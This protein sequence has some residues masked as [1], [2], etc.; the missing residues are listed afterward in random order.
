MLGT[1][2]ERPRMMTSFGP[3]LW[4]MRPGNHPLVMFKMCYAEVKHEFMSVLTV[5]NA[6]KLQ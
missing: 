2:M 4:L 5:T 3:V 6:L 1:V